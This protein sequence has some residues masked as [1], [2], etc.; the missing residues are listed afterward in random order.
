MVSFTA[1]GLTVTSRFCTLSV[2]RIQQPAPIRTARP[3]ITAWCYDEDNSLIGMADYGG[4]GSSPGFF[5]SGGTLYQ[6]KLGD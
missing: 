5:N 6:L 2:Q 1:S 4:N 3:P